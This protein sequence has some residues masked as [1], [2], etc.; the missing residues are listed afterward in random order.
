MP[1]PACNRFVFCEFQC[2]FERIFVD[3][4]TSKSWSAKL[5]SLNSQKITLF[6]ENWKH[7]GNKLKLF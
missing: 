6:Y 5:L 7:L 1:I 4:L 3:A 2:K